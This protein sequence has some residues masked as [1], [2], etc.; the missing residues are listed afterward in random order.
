M[1]LDQQPSTEDILTEIERQ[2]GFI[3]SFFAPVLA[4]PHL[5]E[6]LW[7]QM[8]GSYICNSLPFLFKEQLFAR[9]SCY[10]HVLYCVAFHSHTLHEAGMTATEILML[11]ETPLADA[12]QMEGHLATLAAEA[13]PLTAWPERGSALEQALLACAI[14]LFMPSHTALHASEHLAR[15]RSELERVLGESYHSL[16]TL[17]AYIKWHHFWVESHPEISAEND[18]AL[19]LDLQEE[20]ALADVFQAHCT[21]AEAEHASQQQLLQ[22]REQALA[23][24]RESLSR[25]A[26]E[27]AQLE[28][29]LMQMPAGVVIAEAPSG[30]LVLGN[31]QMQQIWGRSFPPPGDP[32]GYREFKGFHPD[33][34]L[35]EA[36]E[37]PLVRSIATGEVIMAEETMIERSDGSRGTITISASPVR[38]HDGRIVATVATFY[39]IS[40]R[41]LLE[42]ALQNAERLATQRAQQL[43]AIFEAMVEGV[44]VYDSDAR[45]LQMNSA[46]RKLLGVASQPEY[47][48]S[49]VSQRAVMVS[50][51]DKQEK[52]FAEGQ[53][54]IERLL[55]GETLNDSSSVDIHIHTLDG[56]AVILNISGAPIH[57]EQGHITGAVTVNRDVTGQR[58]L[59]RRT[60]DT[61]NALLEMAE[62]MVQAGKDT[63]DPA[64]S[65]RPA[66]ASAVGHR[67]AE[68]TCSVLGCSRVAISAV[69]AETEIVQT[70]AVVG[71]SSE[72]ERHLWQAQ[73]QQA[74]SLRNSSIPELATR[75]RANEILIIDMTQPP[76]NAAPNPYEIHSM[77]L[78]PMYA[79]NELVGL[80]SLD[81][82]AT[83][84]TYTDDELALTQ[85]V[86]RLG[87]LVI[88]RGRLLH[89]QASAHASILALSEAN[90]RM[91]NFLSMASHELRTPLT[92]IKGNI[93]LVQRRLHNF[94]RQKGEPH[95]EANK[96]IEPVQQLLER[97]DRQVKLL[98]RLVGDLLDVSRIQAS[99]LDMLAEPFDLADVVREA[100]QEQ[101]QAHPMRTIFLQ[102]PQQPVPVSGD[103]DRI[104]QVVTNFL[105][106]ALKYSETDRPVAVSLSIEAGNALLH[107]RDEGPGLPAEEQEHIWERF[108]QA[109]GIAV[110]SGSGIGLGLGLHISKTIIERHQGQ[111]GVESTVG[112]GST[113]WFALP[114][115]S[116]S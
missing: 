66:T 72:Q 5:L 100:V 28:A 14:S 43:E 51:H 25:L 114:L 8:R 83:A 18:Q 6:N 106:N 68:L 59:A 102:L 33:G 104:C 103:A 30:K 60:H 2:F 81:F 86:A 93:Q 27:R 108:Y 47:A 3:P 96:T 10:C 49:L 53:L 84:H 20:P 21:K 69:E 105:T 107:V 12:A 63:G 4:M 34:R 74:G 77:L 112:K 32:V 42:T 50:I 15:S 98:N 97:A 75:L 56:R 70:V 44:I 29:V 113:F 64:S 45:I 38:D 1:Q 23:A 110:R 116:V 67:L 48:T 91:D 11:L 80:L 54:P 88:E 55:R 36:Q 13:G 109:P 111:I 26:I 79:G 99:K 62:V 31:E 95:E 40:G 16:T 101:Q 46:A 92:S 57:D 78:A 73:E 58:Q 87:A 76:F 71:L 39:D 82:G 85:A 89:E 24:Q 19:R 22:E 94:T 115:L 7:Q 61:L 52:P 17:L 37:W 65:Y 35:Y 41:K 9:L 90:R